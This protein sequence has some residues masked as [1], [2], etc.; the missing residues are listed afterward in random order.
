MQARDWMRCDTVFHVYE[1]MF[2][3]LQVR[4]GLQYV[5]NN[6]PLITCTEHFPVS[7][8]LVSDNHLLCELELKSTSLNCT[9]S[10]EL[11]WLVRKKALIK[12]W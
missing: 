1:C 3:V 7:I 8:A 11:N 12:V 4:D 6:H 9:W 10:N 2:K 5:Y